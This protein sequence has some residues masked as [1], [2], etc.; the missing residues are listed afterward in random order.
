MNQIKDLEKI[1]VGISI[2]D[3][4]GVGVEIIL[5][6]FEIK[7]F[8]QFFIPIVFC[9]KRIVVN[10]KRHFNLKTQLNFIDKINESVID[11]LNIKKMMDYDG[12]LCFGEPSKISGEIALNSFLEGTKALKKG[13][14]D[15]LVTGPLDKSTIQRENYKF[16]GHTGYLNQEFLGEA[17]M[18]M[19]SDEVKI[20]LVSEHIP[21]SEV[22]SQLSKELL[23]KRIN[24]LV[25]TLRLDFG[26]I[27]Q[28]IAI[29]GINPHAGDNGF[30]GGEEE[31]II[32][33]VIEEFILE[34]VNVCGPFSADGFFGSQQHLK[35][36]AVLAMYHDQGI[37]PFK[38]LSFGKGINFTAGLDK[39]R[40]SPDHGTAYDI[41]GKG[42]VK[43]GSFEKALFLG[44]GIFFMRKHGIKI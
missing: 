5:K 42:I 33:P 40:T 12:A 43:T 14:I 30:I 7:K 34:G 29:L 39:I 16:L 9:P 32:R 27:N 2:G 17:M 38:T 3:P 31:N 44:R 11:K 35:Y 4:N 6:V 8:F 23:F 26:I 10:Q 37:I 15:L 25:E 21:I 22:S 19:V 28:K 24:Q 36:D 20:A 41:A 1:K 18:L 13:A